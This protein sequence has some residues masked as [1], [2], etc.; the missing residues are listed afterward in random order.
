MTINHIITAWIVLCVAA[1]L[2]LF[3]GLF[4]AAARPTV[5]RLGDT[6]TTTEA[7]NGG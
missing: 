6:A 2:T 5:G 1:V 4:M 3:I 7:S